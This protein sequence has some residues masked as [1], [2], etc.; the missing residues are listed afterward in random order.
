MVSYNHRRKHGAQSSGE[1]I[2]EISGG[3]HHEKQYEH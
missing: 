3:N 1:K 2:K